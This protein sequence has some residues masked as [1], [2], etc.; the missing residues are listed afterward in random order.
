MVRSCAACQTI[1]RHRMSARLRPFLK[2]GLRILL[3]LAGFLDEMHPFRFDESA[4]H[5]KSTIEIERR[6]NRLTYIAKN[7]GL[8][9]PASLFLATTH[10]D[11]FAKDRKSVV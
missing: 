1:A 11:V 10:D 9:S 6:D 5:I 7:G 3:H 4:R 8:L 2:G